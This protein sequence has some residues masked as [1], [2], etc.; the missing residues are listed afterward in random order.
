MVR[1]SRFLLTTALA[2]SIVVLGATVTIIGGDRLPAASATPIVSGFGGHFA[3]TTPDG[4][5]V[6]DASYRGRW[7]VIYFGYTSCPDACPT[8]LSTISL[9]LEQLGPDA[10]KVQPL[11]ITV[12]PERDTPKVLTDYVKAFG[13]RLQALRGTP[14]QI[15]AAAKAYHVTYVVRD[16]GDGAYSV[17]HSSFIYVIDPHGKFAQLLTG[18]VP[19]HALSAELRLLVK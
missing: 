3:L 17:D 9:A 2:G 4:Q 19:G 1:K 12:D 5:G 18:D 13:P 15:A 16:L 7:L 14:E 11:F 10:D 8:A 6:T